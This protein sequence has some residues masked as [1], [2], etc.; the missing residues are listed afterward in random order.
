MTKHSAYSQATSLALTGTH[1][2]AVLILQAFRLQLAL[3]AGQQDPIGPCVL[4]E[5]LHIKPHHQPILFVDDSQAPSLQL[6]PKPKPLYPSVDQIAA[7]HAATA[8]VQ[9]YRDDSYRGSSFEYGFRTPQGKSAVSLD[10]AESISSSPRA[11]PLRMMQRLMSHAKGPS[12]SHMT[13]HAAAEAVDSRDISVSEETDPLCLRQGSSNSGSSSSRLH[14]PSHGSDSRFA[15]MK[16]LTRHAVSL[17]SPTKLAATRRRA[18]LAPGTA[19]AA[20]H[21]LESGLDLAPV[22]YDFDLG[23]NLSSASSAEDS[24]GGSFTDAHAAP[25]S[26]GLLHLRSAPAL[27]S[28]QT[29]MTQDDMAAVGSTRGAAFDDSPLSGAMHAATTALLLPLAIQRRSAT[30]EAVSHLLVQDAVAALC[31]GSDTGANLLGDASRQ[32]GSLQTD[33]RQNGTLLDAQLPND[34]DL[35]ESIEVPVAAV[36]GSHT[37]ATDAS[38]LPL[39]QD[40]LEFSLL[41]PE[42]LLEAQDSESQQLLESSPDMLSSEQQDQQ[43]LEQAA[44]VP[45]LSQWDQQLLLEQPGQR[46]SAAQEDQQLLQQPACAS[47]STQMDQQLDQQLHQQPACV[48]YPHQQDQQLLQQVH[49]LDP[50]LLSQSPGQI[51]PDDPGLMPSAALAASLQQ[52]H[53]MKSVS[54]LVPGVSSSSGPLGTVDGIAPETALTASLDGSGKLASPPGE[55]QQVI[56]L[57]MFLS[58][59]SSASQGFVYAA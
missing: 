39:S 47:S 42:T 36:N 59:R 56:A 58:R 45:S 25:P 2:H 16:S 33:S 24:R 31:T 37:A 1:Q 14:G 28:R 10:E 27:S 57:S 46:T 55:C 8:G 26:T 35:C 50:L 48:P 52:A 23:I 22:G 32:N 20:G 3:Q 53:S 30:D 18:T 34:A 13:K 29:S 40:S 21:S 4:D 51:L 12:R 38:L 54:D 17:D 7:S 15:A 19:L 11:S 49:S 9:S 44:H 5:R 6:P 43:L 41:D